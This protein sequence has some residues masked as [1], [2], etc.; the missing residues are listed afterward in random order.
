M[1]G[2]HLQPRS[3]LRSGC[4]LPRHGVQAQ[5]PS[6]FATAA[7]NSNQELFLYS[8][9]WSCTRVRTHQT[10]SSLGLWTET[11]CTDE[12]N[13]LTQETPPRHSQ[14]IKKMGAKCSTKTTTTAELHKRPKPIVGFKHAHQCSPLEAQQNVFVTTTSLQALSQLLQTPTRKNLS[15][16]SLNA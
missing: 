7:L 16:H 5:A 10:N 14:S 13:T 1:R 2:S 6:G 11:T 12:T 8:K 15:I 3:K 9:C 4:T